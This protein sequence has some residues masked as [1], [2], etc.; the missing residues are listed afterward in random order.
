[1]KKFIE[2]INPLWASIVAVGILLSVV[3]A[4]AAT[5][6]LRWTATGD[7][8]YMGTATRYEIRVSVEPITGDNWQDATLLPDV[9]V[10]SISGTPEEYTVVGLARGGTYYFGIVVYDEMENAS[11][12]SNIRRVTI[13]CDATLLARYDVDCSGELDI[14]D[15]IAQVHFMFGPGIGDFQ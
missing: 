8:G 9:Q 1:M 12:L 2:V 11:L 3:L 14:A 6:N 13:L 15:L 5:T 10:P 7:D 4:M